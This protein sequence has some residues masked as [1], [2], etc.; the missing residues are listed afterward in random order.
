MKPSL[1]I[2]LLEHF[3]AAAA[4][5]RAKLKSRKRFSSVS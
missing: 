1:I 5:R 4:K 2:A 3:N